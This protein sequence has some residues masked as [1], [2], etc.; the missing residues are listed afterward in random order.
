MTICIAAICRN[1]E[2]QEVIVFAT[3]HMVSNQAVG[4]FEISIEKYKVISDNIVAMLS[5][6]PLIFNNLLLNCP[7]KCTFNETNQLIYDNM[8]KYKKE[9]LQKQVLD[10]FQITY[11]YIKEVLRGPI[12]NEYIENVLRLISEF[13]LQTSILLIGFE[14]NE[15]QIV[16]IMENT[17][18]D[19]RD[20]GFA[21]IGSGGVQ[22]LNT[23]LFQRQAKT[24][25]LPITLYNVYK[26]KRNAEVSIG[27]GRETDIMVLSPTEIF[28][29]DESK[30]KI[31]NRP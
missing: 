26:A 2:G 23:L 13:S 5:G 20:I 29:I 17:I 10:D 15:A 6:N 25:P 22:A 18:N 1:I 8:S 4:Q 3:D 12:Q 21:A 14:S 24:D 28:K 19:L 16:E 11:D 9:L 27:V 30:E 31:L 7:E